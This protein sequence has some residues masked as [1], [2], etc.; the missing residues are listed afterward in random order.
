MA[1]PD[2]QFATAAQAQAEPVQE[3]P[4]PATSEP[5]A[6]DTD[7][8]VS[9]N[10]RLSSLQQIVNLIVTPDYNLRNAIITDIQNQVSAQLPPA[11]PPV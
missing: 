7:P 6:P 4:T 8:V 10:F 1:T 2:A 3:Q 11:Q 5:Q 9:L